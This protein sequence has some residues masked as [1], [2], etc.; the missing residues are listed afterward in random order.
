MGGFTHFTPLKQAGR[1]R[2]LF[3]V[4]KILTA[5]DEANI[6]NSVI[7]TLSF[8]VLGTLVN[9]CIYVVTSKWKCC[10]DGQESLSD[11]I[12]GCCKKK[13]SYE[14]IEESQVEQGDESK[15]N[16]VH[17][18]CK[19]GQLVTWV[20]ILHFLSKVAIIVSNIIYL[21]ITKLPDS[22]L[23]KKLEEKSPTLLHLR[24]L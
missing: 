4:D 17:P 18:L 19:S 3:C 15:G 20:T 12:L 23:V 16:K 9:I 14:P 10:S 21:V 13:E 5:M 24:D 1:R 7:L 8:A 22:V 6:K 11:V 2:S